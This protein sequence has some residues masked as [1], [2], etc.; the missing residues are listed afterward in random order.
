VLGTDTDNNQLKAA[1]EKEAV[2]KV[3]ESLAA[4]AK[5]META[6]TTMTATTTV[7]A[8]M[9]TKLTA[10]ALV[11][12]ASRTLLAA[13]AT[14]GATYNNQLKRQQKKWGQSRLRDGDGDGDNGG[15]GNGNGN[16][17]GGGGCGGGGRWM[18]GSGR[19]EA[20]VGECGSKELIT[21]G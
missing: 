17:G 18:I 11:V 14:A 3:A 4:M 21:A 19:R 16:S 6:P 9:T 13:T 10:M 20:T 7:T 1:A 12:A 15:D 2:D 5:T 8:S